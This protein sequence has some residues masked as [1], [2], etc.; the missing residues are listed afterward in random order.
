MLLVCIKT[1]YILQKSTPKIKQTTIQLGINQLFQ[2]LKNR[3]TNKQ[4]L[5]PVALCCPDTY[6]R[7]ALQNRLQKLAK[8]HLMAQDLIA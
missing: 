5:S 4:D 8:W 1:K 6:R 7:C 2:K 3:S